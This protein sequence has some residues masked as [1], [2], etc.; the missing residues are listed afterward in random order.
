MLRSQVIGIGDHGLRGHFVT[1]FVVMEQDI[2][3]ENATIPYQRLMYHC[4]LNTQKNG[5][6][7]LG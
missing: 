5:D 2:E 3:Q 4:G 6:G 7:V 1:P